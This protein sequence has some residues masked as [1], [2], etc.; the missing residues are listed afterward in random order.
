MARN[1]SMQEAADF[2][3]KLLIISTQ[4]LKASLTN[5]C[6]ENI[7]GWLHS[8]CENG[9]WVEQGGQTMLQELTKL[10]LDTTIHSTSD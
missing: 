1:Y 4:H 5:T 8:C 6:K 2:L 3:P 9:M 7:Q 10:L